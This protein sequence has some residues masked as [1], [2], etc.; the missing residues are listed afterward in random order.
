MAKEISGSIHM[1]DELVEAVRRA[2]EDEGR[3]CVVGAVV[4]DG[5][6]RVF[7]ARRSDDAGLLP[8]I[9]D[10]PGGHV[11]ASEPGLDALAREVFEE[12]GWHV[13][14]EPHFLDVCDWDAVVDGSSRLYRELD[15]VVDVAGDLSRPRLA[16]AEHVDHRWLGAGELGQLDGQAETDGGL[17]RHIIEAG[18]RCAPAPSPTFP[19]L[20]VFVPAAQAAPI[21][22][23]RRRWDPAMA[24][25]IAAHVTVAYPSELAGMMRLEGLL[26]EAARLVEPFELRIGGPIHDGDPGEGIF[27]AVDDIDGGLR[28]LR[29]RVL[30]PD[31]PVVQPHV[32]IVHPRTSNLGRAAW[33]HLARHAWTR[34]VTATSVALTAFHDRRWIRVAEHDLR[35]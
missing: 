14:G 1:G 12:T 29:E 31:A 35:Q 9:W 32:T 4:L 11:E 23:L 5:G 18:L 25:Q 20:T 3:R 34:D 8:G 10:L 26:A 7:V 28:E 22:V 24:G 30:G 13:T 19:H 6:G 33:Q 2:A 15:F 17:I 16:P 21:E 27:L